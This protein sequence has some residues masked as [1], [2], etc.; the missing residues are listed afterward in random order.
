M[1]TTLENLPQLSKLLAEK[2]FDSLAKR[3]ASSNEARSDPVSFNIWLQEYLQLSAG[4]V[5]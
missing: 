5:I 4:Q 1:Q 2:C 3:A